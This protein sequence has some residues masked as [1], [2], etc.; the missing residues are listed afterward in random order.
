M[1][2]S[3]DNTIVNGPGQIITDSNGNEWQIVDGKVVV[4]GNT[5]PT[6]RNV[7]TL[8]YEGGQV[9]QMNAQRLWWA[10]TS[11]SDAWSPD[12]GTSVS[13]LV[14][15]ASPDNSVVVGGATDAFIAPSVTD[16]NNDHYTITPNGQVAV[17]G[18]V[19]PTT[20]RVIAIAYEKGMVWQ[21]NAD[22]MWWSK[23]NASDPWAP[24]Y[25]TP[26]SPVPADEAIPGILYL[27]GTKVYYT[28]AVTP[29]QYSVVTAADGDRGVTFY[30]RGSNTNNGAIRNVMGTLNLEVNG[31]LDN[32]GTL[33]GQGGI[34]GTTTNINLD[35]F[36]IFSNS[37]RIDI[38]NSS[39]V[40][41]T[42]T[43]TMQAGYSILNNTGVIEANGAK[44]SLTLGTAPQ[45]D[46]LPNRPMLGH[47]INQG[48]IEVSDG[49]KMV[50]AANVIGRGTLE[51]DNG[52]SIVVDGPV[53]AGQTIKLNSS[54]LEFG[55]KGSG[56]NPS[57]QFL[58]KI[59]GDT[60]ASTITLDGAFGTS[61]RLNL[62]NPGGA[63]LSELQVFNP[64][65]VVV[66]DLKFV[67]HFQRSDFTITPHAG[68]SASA[69]WTSVT[70][71][72]HA[73]TTWLSH[74]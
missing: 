65:H 24:A 26:V 15:V 36:S 2:S 48:L 69:D 33:T 27:D 41:N 64:A 31:S 42:L 12:Y 8:A 72:D 60:A 25:G 6:T 68:G 43:V 11:P 44:D 5:D 7:V 38:N 49:A 67:G 50:L 51:A 62:L 17:D 56:T 54:H 1:T 10:K 61:A 28:N 63:G 46:Q 14:G 59:D 55:P 19:D 66:A 57:M 52:S 73:A 70:L 4:N 39:F 22:R 32:K 71:T 3:P 40:S 74:S 45:Q 13:P 29:A 34:G 9:W 37:G 35:R 16:A 23:S 18:V 47:L 53:G 20:R 21:E 30:Y 58:G